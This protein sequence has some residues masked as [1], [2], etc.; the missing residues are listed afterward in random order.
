MSFIPQDSGPIYFETT[1]SD[2][3]WPIEP[4]NTVS[5]LVF[6]LI[7]FYWI[8]HAFTHHKKVSWPFRVLNT[9]LVLGWLGGTLY[10][11]T[12]SS[13]VWYFMDMLPIYTLAMLVS[14]WIWNKVYSW[15]IG[16][17]CFVFILPFVI[18]MHQIDVDS[19]WILTG[20]SALAFGLI[21]PVCLWA[22]RSRFRFFY[23]FLSAVFAYGVALYFR[24]YDFALSETFHHGTHFLWHIGG[25]VSVHLVMLYLVRS[26]L[27]ASE[28]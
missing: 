3:T 10:H 15:K 12:R 18:K 11:G 17:L 21:L 4:W 9:L 13:D 1:L 20:Y 26:N 23:G 6:L 25:G 7:A 28:N 24:Q 19:T 16:L 5:N 22:V 8:W 2:S 14:L 27:L